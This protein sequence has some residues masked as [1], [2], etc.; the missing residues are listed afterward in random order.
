MYAIGEWIQSILNHL[1]W[2]AVSTPDG[3]GEMIADKWL[4]LNN[5]IVNIH[6][7]HGRVFE[8][9]AHGRLP[10]AQNR[11]KKWLKAGNNIF[12]DNGPHIKCCVGI[13]LMPSTLGAR[14]L[15]R[16]HPATL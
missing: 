6:T 2:C 1:Y 11:K 14:S 15:W 9:C 12:Y 7:K 8:K 10:A 13:D 5:H 4:S 3:N 16:R